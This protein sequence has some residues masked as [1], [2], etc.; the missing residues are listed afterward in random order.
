MHAIKD[1]AP[2]GE[3]DFSKVFVNIM[4]QIDGS[5]EYHPE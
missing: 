3:H 4:E 5:G 2:S 1:Q